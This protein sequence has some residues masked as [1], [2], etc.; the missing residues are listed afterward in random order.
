MKDIIKNALEL[1]ERQLK[2]DILK[3]KECQSI[4]AKFFVE[5]R[6]YSDIEKYLNNQLEQVQKEL[7]ANDTTTKERKEK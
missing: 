4:P 3:C 6:D 5:K 7:R 1:Y 2:I